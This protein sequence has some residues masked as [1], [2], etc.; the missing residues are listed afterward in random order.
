MDSEPIYIFKESVNNEE[1]RISGLSNYS[2]VFNGKPEFQTA[3][4][5]PGELAFILA[6]HPSVLENFSLENLPNFY[7][8]IFLNP[9]IENKRRY[10]QIFRESSRKHGHR[11]DSSIYFSSFNDTEF[12]GFKNIF[13]ANFLK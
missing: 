5:L 4:A 7:R 1:N 6:N 3:A 8:S 13:D 11:Q 9:V 12:K 10:E 2:A